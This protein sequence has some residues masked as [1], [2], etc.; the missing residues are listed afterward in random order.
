MKK[1]DHILFKSYGLVSDKDF[2]EGYKDFLEGQT[3]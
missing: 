1:R 2:E 3:C